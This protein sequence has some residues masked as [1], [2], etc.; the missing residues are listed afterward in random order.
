MNRLSELANLCA[1]SVAAFERYQSKEQARSQYE[2]ETALLKFGIRCRDNLAI[3]DHEGKVQDINFAGLPRQHVSDETLDVEF[4]VKSLENKKAVIRLSPSA[5]ANT[6]SLKSVTNLWYPPSLDRD[7][8]CDRLYQG[9][10]KGEL[11]RS[12]AL[13][14][15]SLLAEFRGVVLTT[16][17]ELVTDEPIA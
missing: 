13:C 17:P 7:V 1:L 16:Y 5:M 6:G 8:V 11:L 14:I 3:A 10:R 2:P 12:K 9:M 4:V 15:E